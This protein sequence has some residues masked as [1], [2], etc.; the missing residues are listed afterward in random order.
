MYAAFTDKRQLYSRIGIMR[1]GR[2]Y[3][4]DPDSGIAAATGLNIIGIGRDFETPNHNM[5]EHS[6]R[7]LALR[8]DRC[9][10]P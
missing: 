1:S 3:A 9:S 8:A 7:P 2:R 4:V 10:Y 5:A 6:I